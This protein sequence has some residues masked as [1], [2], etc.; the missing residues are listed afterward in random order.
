[1]D[2]R[3]GKKIRMGRLFNQKSGRSLI[4]AYSRDLDG[5]TAGH[6]NHGRHAAPNAKRCLGGRFDGSAWNALTPG[7]RFRG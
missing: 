2:S 1:M 4:V 6:E 7:R 5:T 3:T